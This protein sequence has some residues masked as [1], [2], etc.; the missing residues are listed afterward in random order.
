MNKTE[1]ILNSEGLEPQTSDTRSDSSGNRNLTFCFSFLSFS[2]ILF[3]FRFSFRPR[4]GGEKR[5][6][7]G[8][9]WKETVEPNA[10]GSRSARTSALHACFHG[11]RW[12]RR[13]SQRFESEQ[14]SLRPELLS[15]LVAL[16]PFLA[17]NVSFSCF[18]LSSQSV[19]SL[20]FHSDFIVVW[21]GSVI[22]WLHQV[23][24]AGLH[25]LLAHFLRPVNKHPALIWITVW[26]LI[27][28][29]HVAAQ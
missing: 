23:K 12:V 22:S 27:C 8:S 7:R 4:S 19:S 3:L 13:C 14:L 28:R 26:G 21:F 25:P 16:F 29:R 18:N 17:V 11:N 15:A 1:S 6:R 5:G 10:G 2:G 20:H 24:V 9:C